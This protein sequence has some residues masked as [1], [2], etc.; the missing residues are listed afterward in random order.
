MASTQPTQASNQVSFLISILCTRFLLVVSPAAVM[1]IWLWPSRLG[2]IH[3]AACVRD[4]A[5]ILLPQTI[6]LEKWALQCS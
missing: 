6:Q 4:L 5:S 3:S 2:W 1:A